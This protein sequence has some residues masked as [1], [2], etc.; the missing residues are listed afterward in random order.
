MKTATLVK[1]SANGDSEQLQILNQ[2][3]IDAVNR[4]N[5]DWFDE[6]LADDFLNSNPDGSL[7]DRKSFL[8]QIEHGVGVSDIET[9]DVIVRIIGDLGLIHARTTYTTSSG[10]SGSGRYTDIY[11]RIDERWICVAAQ[12]TRC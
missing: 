7:S 1:T 5:V 11:S 4:R 10:K 2:Q 9:H 8:K 3:Y 12:V 6:H